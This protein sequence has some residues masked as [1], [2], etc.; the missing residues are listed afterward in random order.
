MAVIFVDTLGYATVVPII[1]FALRG[2][3]VAPAGV[4]AVFA[5][6]SLCQLATAPFLGRLSDK[7]GRRPVLA[8]SQAGSAVGWAMLALSSAYPVVL[9]SRVVD[10]CS[11]GNVA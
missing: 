5:A 4:G 3:G 10:G 6:F 9:L 2:H 7:I 1:P 11:A 8:L